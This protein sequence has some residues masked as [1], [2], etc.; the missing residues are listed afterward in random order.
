MFSRDLWTDEVLLSFDAV[1]IDSTESESKPES[2]KTKPKSKSKK[3]KYLKYKL[4]YIN[5]KSKY[6]IN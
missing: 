5:L 3:Y 2:K 6:M 1:A 4:K